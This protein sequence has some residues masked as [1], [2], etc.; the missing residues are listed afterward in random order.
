MPD[1]TSSDKSFETH[2]CHYLIFQ[3]SEVQALLREAAQSGTIQTFD[4][5]N[6]LVALKHE[7]LKGGINMARLLCVIADDMARRLHEM[8]GKLQE[9]WKCTPPTPVA[10]LPTEP[11]TSSDISQM[12]RLSQTEIEEIRKLFDS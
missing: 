6:H 12:Q 1:P 11:F 7:S 3:I 5:W 8:I 2:F 9:P 10:K 4:E